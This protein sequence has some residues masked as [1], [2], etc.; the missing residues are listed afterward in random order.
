MTEITV[1]AAYGSVVEDEGSLFIGFAAGEDADE[2]YVLFRQDLGGGPVLDKFVVRDPAPALHQF[3]LHHGQHATKALQRQ[4]GEGPEQ[5]TQA[6]RAWVVVLGG[7][8]GRFGDVRVHGGAAKLRIVRVPRGGR[9]S[10]AIAKRDAAI[11]RC[12]G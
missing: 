5:L 4:P 10:L 7:T 9:A 2:G 11:S 1:K 3:A 12:D 6:V 8:G